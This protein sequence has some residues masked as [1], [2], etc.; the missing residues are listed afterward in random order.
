MR[1]LPAHV[2]KYVERAHTRQADAYILDLEDSVPDD[3]KAHARLQLPGAVGL[4][5]Q[6]GAAALVRVNSESRHLAADIQAAC[7]PGI[8][9]LV[10]K[11]DRSAGGTARSRDAA[12][13]R[14]LQ[15][16]RLL[17]F[18]RTSYGLVPEPD[19]NWET[20]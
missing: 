19:L 12:A 13:R 15:R 11:D 18:P 4:V 1:F 6:G 16:E 14:P 2:K 10:G 5:T 20:T 8:S 9:A 17:T 7:L 3:G